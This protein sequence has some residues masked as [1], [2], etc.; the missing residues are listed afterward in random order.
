M[1]YFLINQHK[2]PAHWKWLLPRSIT[3]LSFPNENRTNCSHCPSRLNGYIHE[4]HCCAYR[5]QI[6][7]FLIGLS[8][9]NQSL[10]KEKFDFLNNK[11][12]YLPLA[13]LETPWAIESQKEISSTED[14]AVCDYWQ[15]EAGCTIHKFRNH[16]CSTF[17]CFS[18]IGSD[19]NLWND[20]ADYVML[21]ENNLSFWFMEQMGFE[22][23]S[24]LKTLNEIDAKSKKTLQWDATDL[25]SIWNRWYGKEELFFLKCADIFTK[26]QSDLYSI[27]INYLD[28]SSNSFQSTI[29]TH[30][31]SEGN[32]HLPAYSS[33]IKALEEKIII[34]FNELRGIAKP[35]NILKLNPNAKLVKPEIVPEL[36]HYFPDANSFLVLIDSQGNQIDFQPLSN[37]EQQLFEHIL[38]SDSKVNSSTLSNLDNNMLLP[39]LKL[40]GFIKL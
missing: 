6:A 2:M 36:S 8:L 22:T 30:A 35:N 26:H 19:N 39:G 9:K 37:N 17:F 3:E 38:S 24:F 12:A 31:S 25:K 5:P 18:T 16:M 23:T 40:R 34:N 14:L 10:S 27:A 29:K 11:G 4:A 33:E 13:T 1:E 21:L 7:N 20:L 28:N 32:T 15:P